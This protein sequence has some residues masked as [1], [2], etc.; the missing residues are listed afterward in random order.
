MK[1][2]GSSSL[3]RAA[4][5]GPLFLRV[6]VGA[7]FA[8]HGWLKLDGGVANFA[9]FL[10]SLNVP[11]PEVV[12]WLQ[13]IAEGVGGVLLI[14]G[15]F[16]RFAVVPLIVVSIGALWLVKSSVGFVAPDAAGGELDV[17]LLGG[18]LALLFLGPGRLSVDG[19]LG[20]EAS[21][22]HLETPHRRPPVA[23]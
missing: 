21:A 5:L 6:G 9:A 18:E 10:E 11:A 15:L 13:I 23:A 19:M 17:A 12:A 4:D 22:T 14:L 16:T 7:V 20:I 1:A 8:W 3:G 2:L